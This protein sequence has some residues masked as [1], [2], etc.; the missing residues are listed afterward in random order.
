MAERS[1][2]RRDL[3]QRDYVQSVERGLAVILAFADRHLTV[4][5]G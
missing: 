4:A 5:T 2:D 1:D 3:D